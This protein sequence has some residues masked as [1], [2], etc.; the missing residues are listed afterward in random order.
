MTQT[1][2]NSGILLVLVGPSGVGKSTVARRLA[3][4]MELCYIVSVTTRPQSP[5][6]ENG[7]VYEHVSQEE[8]FRRLDAGEFL[9]Y[10]PVYDDFY[11]TPK[12]PTLD[13]IAEGRDILLEIDLQGAFQVRY[14]YPKALLVFLLP[15]DEQ[16]LLQRL[17]DRGRDSAQ[18]IQRRFRSARREIQMAYG[19]GAF[20]GMVVNDDVDRAVDEIA[21]IVNTRK[22]QRTQSV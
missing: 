2:S 21:K 13:Y 10:A 18:A 22:F 15:P 17:T 19:S 14:H 1:T 11:A 8:F 20:D 16:T 4:K 6:D 3:Q 12:H 5:G 7:K 9:E